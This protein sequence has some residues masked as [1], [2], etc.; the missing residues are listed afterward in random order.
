[1]VMQIKLI[2]VVVVDSV[3]HTWDRQEPRTIQDL[4]HY[5]PIHAGKHEVVEDDPPPKP[6]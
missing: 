1:M 4:P 2:V 5:H 3:L 6:R